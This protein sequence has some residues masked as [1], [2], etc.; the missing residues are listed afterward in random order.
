MNVLLFVIQE[1]LEIKILIFNLAGLE[2]VKSSALI[3]YALQVQVLLRSF[4][5]TLINSCE[6]AF[7]LYSTTWLR[8]SHFKDNIQGGYAFLIQIKN[9]F[10]FLRFIEV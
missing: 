4:Q 1:D 6:T 5:T 8:M 10:H 9:E 2:V 3:S 7:S